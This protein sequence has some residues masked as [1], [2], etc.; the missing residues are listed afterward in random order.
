MKA[1][2]L[3]DNG[4]YYTA[5]VEYGAKYGWCSS[6]PGVSE[7]LSIRSELGRNLTHANNDDTERNIRQ[8]FF[9]HNVHLLSAHNRV[10]SSC[11]LYRQCTRANGCHSKGG[12]V[13]CAEETC[14]L[15]ILVRRVGFL[16][17]SMRYSSI[18]PWYVTYNTHQI[19]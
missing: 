17:C 19:I 14:A 2:I 1:S 16:F 13:G 10:H 8:L 5:Q 3:H 12:D 9:F 6:K 11:F 7:L 15:S 4:R 18:G